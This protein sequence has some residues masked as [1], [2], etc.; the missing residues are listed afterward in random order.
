MHCCIHHLPKSLQKQLFAYAHKHADASLKLVRTQQLFYFV[1]KIPRAEITGAISQ[2]EDK[3]SPLSGL[4]EGCSLERENL[5]Y[6]AVQ[7]DVRH[8]IR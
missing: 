6:G 2:E 5:I 8:P 7:A 4:A 3:C 1:H